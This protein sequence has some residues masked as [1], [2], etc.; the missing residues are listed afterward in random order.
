MADKV[1]LP[2][3]G[4]SDDSAAEATTLRGLCLSCKELLRK[5]TK[6]LDEAQAHRARE[7]LPRLNIWASNVGILESGRRSLEF[8]LEFMPDISILMRLLLQAL[9]RDLL[10]VGKPSLPPALLSRGLKSVGNRPY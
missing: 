8:K 7:Q 2:F 5:L 10:K 3:L 1:H 6:S 4:G 9:E